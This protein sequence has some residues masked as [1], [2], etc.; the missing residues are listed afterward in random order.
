MRFPQCE[1]HPQS[2]R[3][4][5]NLLIQKLRVQTNNKEPLQIA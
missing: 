2:E 4:E 3:I 5:K 1:V